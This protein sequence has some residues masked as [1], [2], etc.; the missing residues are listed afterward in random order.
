M[1]LTGYKDD[2]KFKFVNDWLLNF[3]KLIEEKIQI[4]EYNSKFLDPLLRDV[5]KRYDG[6][7]WAVTISFSCK[8]ARVI[9]LTDIKI[10]AEESAE[11]IGESPALLKKS[12]EGLELIISK[13]Q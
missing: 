7:P 3:H 8:K 10:D 13:I 11:T 1:S 4:S 2:E 5:V 12:K 9:L 6:E